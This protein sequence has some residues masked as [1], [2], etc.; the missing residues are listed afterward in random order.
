MSEVMFRYQKLLP[1][2]ADGD[3]GLLF[4]KYYP[5]EANWLRTHGEALRIS[6]Y[7]WPEFIARY[8]CDHVG[9]TVFEFDIWLDQQIAER[10]GDTFNKRGAS[11]T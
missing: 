10:F 11:D 9:M 4:A 7:R 1:S 2:T 5:T 3:D 8:V 6:V